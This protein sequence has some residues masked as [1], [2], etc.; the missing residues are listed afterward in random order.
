MSLDSSDYQLMPTNFLLSAGAGGFAFLMANLDPIITVGLPLVL[1][2]LGKGIDVA[3][4]L[5]LE[6]K[7]PNAT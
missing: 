4:K 6:K 7:K 5:Y 1:F 3:V 2:V